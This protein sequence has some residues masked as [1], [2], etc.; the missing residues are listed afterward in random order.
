MKAYSSP[1]IIDTV[2][3]PFWKGN[4]NHFLNINMLLNLEQETPL[5]YKR[6]SCII[7][8]KI[9]YRN[10][11][12]YNGFYETTVND[13]KIWNIYS[14]LSMLAIFEKFGLGYPT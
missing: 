12:K 5:N 10:Y 11:G 13:E 3:F 6:C 2:I 8:G 9:I 14:L 1:R 4:T 7:H